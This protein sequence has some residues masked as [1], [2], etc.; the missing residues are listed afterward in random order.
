ME[1]GVVER[2]QGEWRT[3]PQRNGDADNS[4]RVQIHHGG[5]VHYIST[6][7]QFGE[8]SRLDVVREDRESAAQQVGIHPLFF[9]V[10]SPFSASAAVGLNPVLTHHP[11]YAL[12]VHI[13]RNRQPATVVAG[14]AASA[15]NI[16]NVSFQLPVGSLFFGYV[17]QS[18]AG[19]VERFGQGGLVSLLHER[20]FWAVEACTVS[21]P[22]RRSNSSRSFLSRLNSLQVGLPLA[23]FPNQ[24]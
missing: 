14:F 10:F 22:T 24:P 8:V 2:L 20:F 7:P 4:S 3:P 6:I 13:Q 16:F 11:L 15:K 12:A 23:P 21:S 9:C 18:R 1:E 5:N 17:V 19:D